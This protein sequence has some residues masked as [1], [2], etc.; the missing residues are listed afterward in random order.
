MSSLMPAAISL[1]EKYKNLFAA[2]GVGERHQYG[3]R[4]YENT[5]YSE[6]ALENHPSCEGSVKLRN[7]GS[8]KGELW[9]YIPLPKGTAQTAGTQRREPSEPDTARRRA[10]TPSPRNGD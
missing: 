10:G 2:E 4:R 6:I 8:D 5:I 3:G 9:H 7:E 1:E